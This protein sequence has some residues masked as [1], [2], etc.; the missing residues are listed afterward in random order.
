MVWFGF[1]SHLFEPPWRSEQEVIFPLEHLDIYSFQSSKSCAS[2]SASA[3][4]CLGP[5]LS[6]FLLFLFLSLSTGLDWAVVPLLGKSMYKEG[7]MKRNE[8]KKRKGDKRKMSA[9]C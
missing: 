9:Q 6:I 3:S 1:T 8:E 4:V 5:R 2:A 7:E